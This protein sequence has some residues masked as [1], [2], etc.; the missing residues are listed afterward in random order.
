MPKKR[1][2]TGN[3]NP[4]GYRCPKL[5]GRKSVSLWL[6]PPLVKALNEAAAR[7]GASRQDVIEE[8]CKEFVRKQGIVTSR[9]HPHDPSPS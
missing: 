6:E 7:I 1:P 9:V 3:R 4:P 8:L 5:Q 2:Y